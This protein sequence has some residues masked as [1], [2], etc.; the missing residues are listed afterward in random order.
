MKTKFNTVVFTAWAS[1]FFMVLIGDVS[2]AW[3]EWTKNAR[4]KLEWDSLEVD[5]RIKVEFEANYDPSI[6]VSLDGVEMAVETGVKY[7]FTDGKR[8]VCIDGTKYR[9]CADIVGFWESWDGEG[10]CIP[11]GSEAA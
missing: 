3:Y 1:L 4:E 9:D 10:D 6:S 7:I 5:C 2:A 8:I 11:G